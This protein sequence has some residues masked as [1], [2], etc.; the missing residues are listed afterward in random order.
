MRKRQTGIA[1]ITTLMIAGLLIILLGAFVGVSRSN[2]TLTGNTVRQQA[3][4][5]LCLSALNFSWYQLERNQGWA[6]GGFP[7]GDITYE[8]PNS[9]PALYELTQHGDT[10]APDDVSLNYIEGRELATGETFE[11]RIINNL[12]NRNPRPS[13][14]LGDVPGRSARLQIRAR[15][16]NQSRELDVVLRKRPFVDSSALSN[17]AMDVHDGI[18]NLRLYS[19]DPYVNQ[20]RSNLDMRLPSAVSNAVNFRDPPRGG[21]AM[22]HDELY[23]AG[24]PIS[25]NPV[26]ESNSEA[27]ANGDFV[28]G[29]S[30]VQVP[31]LER[32]HLTFPEVEVEIPQGSLTLG[33]RL[34]E[35][36]A[37]VTVLIDI[38][39]PPDG[40]PESVTRYKKQ[41]FA[42][43]ALTHSVF[44]APGSTW[45]SETSVL[46]DETD[47][48]YSSP[49]ISGFTDGPAG[50]LNDYPVLYGQDDNIASA[51]LTS[52]E[53][54]LAP[55]TRF[56]V[57]GALNV[58]RDPD[59]DGVS[60]PAPQLKFGF[61]GRDG[62]VS[63]PAGGNPSAIEDPGRFSAALVADDSVIIEGEA[64]GFGSIYSDGDVS[65]RAKPGLRADPNLS[66]AVRGEN[67]RLETPEGSDI[68]TMDDHFA[69]DWEPFREALG[70][71]G[72]PQTYQ[73]LDNWGRLQG[74]ERLQMI[75]DSPGGILE[76]TIPRDANYYW[77]ELSTELN[78]TAPTPSF[79][80]APTGGMRLEHYVRL[81]NYAVSLAEGNADVRWL[82]F[83]GPN[84]ATGTVSGHIGLY[85]RWG[86][87]MFEGDYTFGQFMSQ[88]EP[89]VADLFFVGLVHAQSFLADLSGASIYVEG[90]LVSKGSLRV[91]SSSEVTFNYNRTY[92]DDV[93]QQYPGDQIKLD[94]VY[95]NI[96]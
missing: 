95:F 80:N 38:S 31:D 45:T 20:I 12:T 92:L 52:G 71:P 75:E 41:T 93:V 2:S 25:S 34:R 27:A 21:V 46:F 47:P 50:T 26:L 13:T 53:I 51:D 62:Q 59:A 16:S 96:K 91:E 7:D 44:S 73:A 60:L 42:H 90:A 3:A 68:P 37:P 63:F 30:T 81:R 15:S 89:L 43:T 87:R 76:R 39:V 65:F 82:D 67:V 70:T 84:S 10:S 8:F 5:N 74:V 55:A 33:R 83:D 58:L 79:Q 24:Q 61:L 64:G 86:D 54:Y 22:S 72:I 14:H 66:V 69:S 6:A 78:L 28:T 35:E 49:G 48:I 17:G 85:S 57:P 11:I 77:N 18:D 23:L 32:E 56:N 1:L 94:Q 40:I 88:D 4:H 29:A 19:R 9:G 36:W